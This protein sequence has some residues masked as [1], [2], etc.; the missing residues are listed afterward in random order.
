MKSWHIVVMNGFKQV[1][2]FERFSAKESK[3]LFDELRAKYKESHPH[4]A[5]KREW[6]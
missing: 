2:E 5:V 4:Y 3:E 1:E 6:Y